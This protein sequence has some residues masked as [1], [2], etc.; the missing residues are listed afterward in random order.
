MRTVV[1]TC[2]RSAQRSALAAELFNALA[3]PAKAHAF[4]AEAGRPMRPIALLVTMGDQGAPWAVDVDRQLDWPS[5][6]PTYVVDGQDL[7]EERL[8][9]HVRD[10]VARERWLCTGVLAPISIS[11][12]RP[13]PAPV[14]QVAPAPAPAPSAG[15]WV[16]ARSA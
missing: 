13:S 12:V 16:D 11:V 2:S 14:E 5:L 10:L 1:F 9:R 15:R 3:D 7:F 4:P 8:V 6:D